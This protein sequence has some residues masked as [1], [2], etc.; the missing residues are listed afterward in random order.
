M[1]VQNLTSNLEKLKQDILAKNF[2]KAQKIRTLFLGGISVN[3]I[4][5]IQS[6]GVGYG[7]VYNVCKKAFSEKF[8][9]KKAKTK[10]Q[11]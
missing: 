3:E 5:K 2:S 11:N 6:L 10:H 9:G 1:Q 7:A 8:G 4:S